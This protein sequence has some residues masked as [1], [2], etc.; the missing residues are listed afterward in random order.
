MFKP[1]KVMCTVHQHCHGVRG[2]ESGGTMSTVPTDSV[3][4]VQ[5]R[6]HVEI[7]WHILMI[8]NLANLVWF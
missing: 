5:D 7:E 3:W 8:L 4:L 6:V 2:L 1:L